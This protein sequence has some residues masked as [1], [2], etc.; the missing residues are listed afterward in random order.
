MIEFL[1]IVGCG[2]VYFLVV[3]LFVIRRE[4]GPIIPWSV[5]IASQVVGTVLFMDIKEYVMAHILPP[6]RFGNLGMVIPSA[7]LCFGNAALI[8]VMFGIVLPKITAKKSS[9]SGNT[10]REEIR[11]APLSSVIG[12]GAESVGARNSQ[13]SDEDA[14]ITIDFIRTMI[15]QGRSEE[16]RK[17]LKMLAY[18]GKDDATRKEAKELIAELGAAE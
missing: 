6:E 17:Y 14:D 9:F 10:K 1:K 4:S 5:C 8:F 12:T 13:E 16:A 7:C 11:V 15:S 3:Y 2:I 18:Y